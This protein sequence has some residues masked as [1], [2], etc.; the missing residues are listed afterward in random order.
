MNQAGNDVPINPFT[1][2]R[3]HRALRDFTLSNA[4]R[5][6]S[7]MGNPMA[8]RGLS[9]SGPFFTQTFVIPHF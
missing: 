7:S 9:I 3:A 2:I 4:R 8:V 5:I 6:Y 1:A